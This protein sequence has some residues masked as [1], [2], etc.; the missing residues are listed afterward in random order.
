M[1][2]GDPRFI[3][4]QA[5]SAD[6]NR[7]TV[8]CPVVRDDTNG[9]LD[10]VRF[11]TENRQGANNRPECTV[12]S[13]SVDAGSTDFETEITPAM[14]GTHTLAFSLNG[15]IE[16]DHGHYVIECEMGRGD[17]LISYRTKED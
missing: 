8:M 6:P 9:D 4:Y 3:E 14:N 16:F 5:T 12:W 2:Y 11:R 7:A 1:D 15:F 10:F 13:V 17:R